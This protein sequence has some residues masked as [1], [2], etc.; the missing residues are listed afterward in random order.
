[1]NDFV[2]F[3]DHPPPFYPGWT[4]AGFSFAETMGYSSAESWCVG[5]ENS[6]LAYDM[7]D[8]GKF[9]PQ[10]A[11]FGGEDFHLGPNLGTA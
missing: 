11:G 7:T 9:E 4:N 5:E 1:M 3:A 8:F 2:E 10:Y 6:G